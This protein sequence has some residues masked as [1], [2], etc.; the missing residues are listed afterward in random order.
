MPESINV[1]QN[2]SGPDSNEQER[3]LSQSDY[4]LYEALNVL[5]GMVLSRQIS[6]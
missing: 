6:D 5:K 3:S 4:A 1:N 2:Q